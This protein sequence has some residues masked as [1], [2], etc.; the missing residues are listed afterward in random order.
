ML[1]NWRDRKEPAKVYPASEEPGCWVVEAPSG[2]NATQPTRR[3]S[4]NAAQQQAV[5]FAS[6]AFG[7]VRLFIR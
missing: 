3:F 5:Q 7:G 4:G 6:E 2:A 1:D